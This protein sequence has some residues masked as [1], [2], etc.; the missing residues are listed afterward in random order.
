MSIYPALEPL[1]LVG[2]LDLVAPDGLASIRDPASGHIGGVGEGEQGNAR[3]VD[4]VKE[5][6]VGLGGDPVVGQAEIRRGRGKNAIGQCSAVLLDLDAT[7][8][9]ARPEREGPGRVGVRLLVGRGSEAIMASRDSSADVA[10][11]GGVHDVG[12]VAVDGGQEGQ[13]HAKDVGR[14]GGEH[15]SDWSG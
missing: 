15:F 3:A 7:A 4:A 9:H 10:V 5:D 14:S 8:L 13:Q 1:H 12:G 11:G 6:D 2:C